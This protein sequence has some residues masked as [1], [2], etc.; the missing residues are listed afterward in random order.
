MTVTPSLAALS[1][2]EG[3]HV[4]WKLAS[5]WPRRCQVV[6]EPDVGHLEEN[7]RG[8]T[9][10]YGQGGLREWVSFDQSEASIRVR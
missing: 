5:D 9:L 10:E 7:R 4:T 8:V 1:L 6:T 2:A 3:D